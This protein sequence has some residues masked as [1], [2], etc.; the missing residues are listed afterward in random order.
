M[1]S[2]IT[3]LW[4]NYTMIFLLII[5]MALGAVSVLFILQ[6]T[7]LV[8]VSFLS[9][10]MEGSL[11]LILFLAVTSGALIILLVLFPSF[12]RDAIDLG[13]VRKQKKVLETELAE[14]QEALTRAK[15]A[16]PQQ[17]IEQQSV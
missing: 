12:I 16:I 2:L 3:S 11:A 5:G 14:T 17:H 10:Q 15:T 6:N 13:A 1:L 8:T 7:A 9:W 4:Y